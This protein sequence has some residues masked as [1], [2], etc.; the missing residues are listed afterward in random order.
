MRVDRRVRQYD[1]SFRVC[2]SMCW[3]RSEFSFFNRLGVRTRSILLSLTLRL[4]LLI[5]WF[6][7]CSGASTSGGGEACGGVDPTPIEMC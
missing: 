7:I 2:R 3:R 4:C 5:L 1:Q 6:D